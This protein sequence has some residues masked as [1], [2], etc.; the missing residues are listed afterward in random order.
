MLGGEHLVTLGAIRAV[1]KR[2]PQLTVIHLDAH[3]DL[4][5]H[6]LGEALTHA[7]VIYQCWKLLGDGKIYQFGIR[8]GEKEE[9]DFAKQHTF[10]QKFDL[11]GFAEMVKALRGKPVYFTLDLDVLDPSVF[12]GTGTPEA[13]GVTF[14]ELMEAILQLHSLHLVGAD[15]NELSPHYDPSGTSTAVA[16]KVLREVLLQM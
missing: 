5:E 9:F 1:A 14:K 15:I 12:W 6:Y 2:C 16:C 7:G 10:L 11:T 8:S 13:G 3:T 4:R